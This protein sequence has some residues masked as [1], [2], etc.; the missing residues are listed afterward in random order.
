[1]P[2]KHDTGAKPAPASSDQAS[3]DEGT[4]AVRASKG[5]RKRQ[6]RRAPG[7]PDGALPISR[8]FAEYALTHAL[9]AIAHAGIQVEAVEKNGPALA[10]WSTAYAKNGDR[11]VDTPSLRRD[12]EAALS[13]LEAGASS[14]ASIKQIALAYVSLAAALRR[15]SATPAELLSAAGQA[16][17][18]SGF[19]FA[20]VEVALPRA[21]AFAT[22]QL[23][24]AR[25]AWES[26]RESETALWRLRQATAAA[27]HGGKGG[28][29]RAARF[30]PLREWAKEQ[31]DRPE[32]QR[33]KRNQQVW[34][35]YKLLPPELK[36]ISGNA[37]Q[38]LERE[39]D[40]RRAKKP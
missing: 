26:E 2:T 34:E 13:L 28:A 4:S 17:W 16:I 18:A 40:K 37:H 7:G 21:V 31:F 33:L 29:S 10:R 3:G 20:E 39:L 25:G 8:R 11:G 5:A 23:S 15:R 27:T 24:T 6:G 36:A 38:F 22:S 14:H 32:I 1:M 9:K 35:V 30:E 12:L 19:V